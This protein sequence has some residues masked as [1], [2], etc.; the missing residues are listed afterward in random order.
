MRRTAGAKKGEA[1]SQVRSTVA[2]W[3]VGAL[4]LG[5]QS[6]FK[7]LQEDVF[8]SNGLQ[9]FLGYRPLPGGMLSGEL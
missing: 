2:G 4:L 3:L 1:M 6:G 9:S 7:G 5:C 8:L